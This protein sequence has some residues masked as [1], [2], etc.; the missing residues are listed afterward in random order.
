M[1][2]CAS[3]AIAALLTE[4]PAQMRLLRLGGPAML[5]LPLVLAAQEQLHPLLPNPDLEDAVSGA[6]RG[7]SV[8]FLA[9]ETAIPWSVTLQH[10][11]RYP[12][13]YMGYWMLNAVVRNEMAGNPNPRL[14]ALGRQVVAD[15]VQ[16][17][18]CTPPR[19]II[20]P[21]PRPGE[22]GFDI[23]PFFL[24]DA[25]FAELLSHYRVIG[26]TSFE[27]YELNSPL[28]PRASGCS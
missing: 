24:R 10:E 17:Y 22:D 21:R 3:L 25:R 11:F 2:G 5:A 4:S 8:G 28:R 26:R 12:S 1:L 13:R 18:S 15:T 9:V 23:L 7:D 14:S 20:V 6:Q 27:V 19:R 16:D